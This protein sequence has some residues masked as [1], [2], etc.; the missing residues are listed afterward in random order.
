M[1]GKTAAEH[2]GVQIVGSNKPPPTVSGRAPAHNADVRGSNVAP[3]TT[4]MLT[5][6]SA[7]GVSVDRQRHWWK[8][9]RQ[10]SHQNW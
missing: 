10:E 1:S 8:V 2:A 7:A 4:G 6:A 9:A 3:L 5:A